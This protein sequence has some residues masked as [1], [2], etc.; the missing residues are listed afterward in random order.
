MSLAEN[1]KARLEYE[2]LETFEAGLIL[3][4]PEVKAVRKG[5]VD[6]K[7]SYAEVNANG[8]AYLINC[9]IAP[10]KP[11]SLLQK[12]YSPNQLRKLLLTKKELRFL[13]GK[14]KEKGLA[15]IPLEI[16]L[17]NNYLKVKIAVARGKK[18]FDKRESIKKREFERRK[19]K[20]IN[21]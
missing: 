5:Q 10:Y 21:N 3:S 12:N 8:E 1:K 17:K 15:I 7:G 4:G 18:K 6:L 19:Q 16:F 13:M 11:A 2:I 20:L 9:Y 14:Q